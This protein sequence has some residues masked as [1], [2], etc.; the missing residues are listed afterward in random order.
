VTHIIA[1]VSRKMNLILT[2]LV[3]LARGL[4]SNECRDGIYVA[5]GESYPTGYGKNWRNSETF[6]EKDE[7]YYRS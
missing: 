1:L 5:D 4:K 7:E 3:L 2:L 6:V